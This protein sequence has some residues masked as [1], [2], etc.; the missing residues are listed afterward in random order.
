MPEKDGKRRSI[1]MLA[2]AAD[3]QRPLAASE[4]V[5]SEQVLQRAKFLGGCARDHQMSTY[6]DPVVIASH[7][8]SAHSGRRAG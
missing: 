3:Q 8:S 1:E 6:I 2:E 5:Q 4:S 7:L